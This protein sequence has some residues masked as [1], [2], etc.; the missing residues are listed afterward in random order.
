MSEV[1]RRYIPLIITFVAGMLMI[2]EYYT[3]SPDIGNVADTVN[4][5]RIILGNVVF[6]GTIN[7]IRVHGRRVTRRTEGQWYYSAWTIFLIISFAI[8]GLY[9]GLESSN[10]RW[11]IDN[12]NVPLGATMYASLCF[13]MAAGAYRVLRARNLGTALLLI[14]AFF[15][16]VGNTPLF[17]SIWVGF[18]DIRNGIFDTFVVGSYRSIRIGVG[19]GGV[20]LGIRTIFGLETAYLGRRRE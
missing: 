14:S 18:A 16:I 8:L 20:A 4:T 17:P 5:W 3:V 10:Y 9:L 15:V 12:I 7:L 2:L 13:Y 6:V 11:L 19:L 1:T